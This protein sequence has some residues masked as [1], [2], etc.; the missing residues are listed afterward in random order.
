MLY[1]GNRLLKLLFG[2]LWSTVFSFH[3]GFGSGLDRLCFKTLICLLTGSE[4]ILRNMGLEL[5]H[6]D[7]L[8]GSVILR[9][10]ILIKVFND[11]LAL[12]YKIFEFVVLEHFAL[13][14]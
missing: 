13:S 12:I 9:E 11:F 7:T 4:H 10:K 2:L 1:L 5:P 8:C 14:H 3:C 6:K